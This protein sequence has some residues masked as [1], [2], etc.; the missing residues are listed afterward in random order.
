MRR[1]GPEAVQAA[2]VQALGAANPG[3]LAALVEELQPVLDDA[4]ADRAKARRPLP[5]SSFC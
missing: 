5:P 4:A 3:C 1:V 2:C